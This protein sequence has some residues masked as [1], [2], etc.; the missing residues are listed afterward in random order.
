MALK[1]ERVENIKVVRARG[2]EEQV[3]P[4]LLFYG[5]R[6]TRK[7]NVALLRSQ[8]LR[9]LLQNSQQGR[10][11]VRTF[12]KLIN[13]PEKWPLEVAMIEKDAATNLDPKSIE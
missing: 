2:Q 3:A 12:P 4:P 8:L 13:I 5:V 6:F 7:P 11:D 10:N 1:V 9:V